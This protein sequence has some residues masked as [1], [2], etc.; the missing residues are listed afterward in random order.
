MRKRS[1]LNKTLMQFI[2]CTAALLL[3]ATPLFYWL[4]KLYYA[5][6]LIEVIENI[7]QGQPIPA[8]DLEEDIM[9]GI[10][11][12]FGLI[13]VILGI[14]IVI[15]MSV[16]TKKTWRPF[17]TTLRLTEN[18]R[19]ED[20]AIP[21]FPQS[22]VKEFS[23]L[24]DSLIKLIQNSITSYKSQK[25]FTENASHELQTPLAIFRTKLDIMMQQTGLTQE[26]ADTIQ[27]LYQ[28]INR[29]TLLNRNL[30]L[31][32]KIDNKQYSTLE[33][34]DIKAEISR[35][36]PELETL[37]EDISIRTDF[38]DIP[39]RVQSNKVLFGS[40]VNNLVVNAVRHNR[41]GGHIY[42]SVGNGNLTVANTS[43]VDKPLDATHIFNR[44]Y[45]PAGREKGNGLGLA[46]VKAICKY[47]GWYVSYAFKDSQHVFTVNFN[48]NGILKQET[49]Q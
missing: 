4:T 22:D 48:I 16:I 14:A 17:N 32:A 8:L 45:R 18:F 7:E 29:L 42:I 39:L 15:M 43:D 9:Q 11:I 44:F 33:E 30:L 26:Q 2:A 34:T 46:I 47:H 31:L 23:Q 6:D 36:I 37:A 25:E 10:M 21:Q 5:E 19:L 1:L 40:M 12:Q 35:I 24:N 13:A 3:L 49:A 38:S 28:T 27:E 41:P 20:G